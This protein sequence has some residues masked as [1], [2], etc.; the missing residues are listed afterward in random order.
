MYKGELVIVRRAMLWTASSFSHGES[1]MRALHDG[2][3]Y[4]RMVDV[5]LDYVGFELNRQRTESS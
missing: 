4:V 2:P 3:A 1:D 5:H